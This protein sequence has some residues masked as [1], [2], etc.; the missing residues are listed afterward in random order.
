MALVKTSSLRRRAESE[1]GANVDDPPPQPAHG[2]GE[3]ILFESVPQRS[4]ASGWLPNGRPVL[5]LSQPG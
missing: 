3:E 5:R 4:K 1:T 2:F